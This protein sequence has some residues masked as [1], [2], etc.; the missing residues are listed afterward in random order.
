VSLGSNAIVLYSGV[1]SLLL[2]LLLLQAW[3]NLSKLHACILNKTEA[4]T[5]LT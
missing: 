2:L 4:A 5:L 1:D 3:H